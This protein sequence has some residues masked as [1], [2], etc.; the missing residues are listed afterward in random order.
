MQLIPNRAV[1]L[2][3]LITLCTVLSAL[4]GSPRGMEGLVIPVWDIL[5]QFNLCTGFVFLILG[6]LESVETPVPDFRP[7]LKL[8]FV[9]FIAYSVACMG[10]HSPVA[11]PLSYQLFLFALAIACLAAGWARF[12]FSALKQFDVQS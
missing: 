7:A 2:G 12:G 11:M 3:L 1:G 6:V 5:L 9:A 4:A 8:F 10:A